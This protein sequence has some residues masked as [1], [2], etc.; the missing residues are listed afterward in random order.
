MADREA[1]SRAAEFTGLRAV[2]AGSLRK[3]RAAEAAVGMLLDLNRDSA[4]HTGF[5]VPG[6]DH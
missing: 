5:R 3:S 4:N 2:P 6:L 1:A